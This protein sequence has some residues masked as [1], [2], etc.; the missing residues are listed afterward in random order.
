MTH[1]VKNSGRHHDVTEW[2][3][4]AYSC[5][6]HIHM[7]TTAGRS[8]VH[9]YTL[10][11]LSKR[12]KLNLSIDSSIMV[13]SVIYQLNGFSAHKLQKHNQRYAEAQCIIL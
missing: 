4:G 2:N 6:R 9:E 1:D 5:P 11:F 12:E 7:D 10:L 8:Y 3:A 13:F